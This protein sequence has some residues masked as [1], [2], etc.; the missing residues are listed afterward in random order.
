MP[1][2]SDIDNALLVKLQNDAALMAL[3]P[4]LAHWDLAP[5]GSA[6]YVLVSLS[7]PRDVHTFGQRAIEDNV[8]IVKAVGRESP[9]DTT[10]PDMNAAAARIDA[11]LEGGTLTAAGYTLIAMYRDD[12]LPRIRTTERDEVESKTRWHHRGGYYRVVMST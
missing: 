2:S 4:N 8:Y 10:K 9:L 3:M 6:R 1:N 11:L 5:D 12:D 7:A